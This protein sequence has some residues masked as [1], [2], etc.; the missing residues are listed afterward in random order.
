MNI[1]KTILGKKLPAIQ[2]DVITSYLKMF[3]VLMWIIIRWFVG[4]YMQS[5]P[6]NSEYTLFTCKEAHLSAIM[7]P[8]GRTTLSQSGHKHFHGD[9]GSGLTASWSLMWSTRPLPNHTRDNPKY[10]KID[11]IYMC[12]YMVSLIYYF[13]NY[14]H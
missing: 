4:R 5:F 14:K 9:N 7:N 6:Y 10:K 8:N 13:R 2:C 3:C 11:F 1:L 12:L